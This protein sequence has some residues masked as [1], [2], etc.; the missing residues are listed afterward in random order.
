MS[1]DKNIVFDKYNKK[2]NL[3]SQNNFSLL[4]NISLSIRIYTLILLD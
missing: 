4:K 3:V 1:T 2:E